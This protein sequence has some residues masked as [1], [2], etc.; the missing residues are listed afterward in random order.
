MLLSILALF[1]SV[2]FN[3][4]DELGAAAC[5]FPSLNYLAVV[6]SVCVIIHVRCVFACNQWRQ[7]W[8]VQ[9]CGLTL[10]SHTGIRGSVC[11]S[12]I[13]IKGGNTNNIMKHL[14]TK[15]HLPQ[16]MCCIYYVRWYLTF[17]YLSRLQVQ[18]LGIVH[19]KHLIL[20]LFTHMLYQTCIHF[21][22]VLNTKEDILNNVGNQTVAGSHWLW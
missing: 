14:L 10:Q 21:I 8:N 1:I 6:C 12:E 19:Q 15:Q 11:N 3:V 5:H 13:V 17:Y 2:Y 16:A 7:E 22:L 20:S 18:L 4:N 9:K